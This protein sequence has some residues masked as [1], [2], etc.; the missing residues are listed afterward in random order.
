M[1]RPS[2]TLVL[3][4]IDVADPFDAIQGRDMILLDIYTD[5]IA[6]LRRTFTVVRKL[7]QNGRSNFVK[8]CLRNLK[9]NLL[10]IRGIIKTSSFGRRI[11]NRL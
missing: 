5:M 6:G 10:N 8:L 3:R 2:H 11:Y 1:Q 4:E 7:I 9:R